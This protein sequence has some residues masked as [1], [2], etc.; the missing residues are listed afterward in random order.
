MVAGI[1]ARRLAGLLESTP[2]DEANMRA[3]QLVDEHDPDS[4]LPVGTQPAAATAETLHLKYSFA[5]ERGARVHGLESLTNALRGLGP[6][7][8]SGCPVE[9]AHQFAL[10]FF[11]EDATE[12][13]GILFVS[14]P[15]QPTDG[16]AAF[17]TR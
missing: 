2:G 14:P 17:A 1:T 12:L 11:T 4:T 3:H 9:G 8:V 7:R 15:S 6:A 13:I 10:V 16:I 5:S